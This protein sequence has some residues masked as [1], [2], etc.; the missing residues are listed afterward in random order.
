MVVV[1]VV[2]TGWGTKREIM[3]ERC[4]MAIISLT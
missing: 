3:Y 4:M 1:V 2:G